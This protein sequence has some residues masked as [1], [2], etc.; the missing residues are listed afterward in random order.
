MLKPNWAAAGLA[1]IVLQWTA[2]ATA[3]NP[4]PAVIVAWN[5]RAQATFPAT[6]G[7]TVSRQYAMLHIAM[8]DAV[9]S[10]EH[11]YTPFRARVP[12]SSGASAKAAAAQAAHDVLANLFPANA[13]AYRTFLEQ[14]LAG[15]PVG[16][17]NPGVKVG[18]AVAAEI[19][20]WRATD[21]AFAP[22]VP[23][24]LPRIPGLWQPTGAPAGMTQVP[25]ITPFTLESATH[26]LVPR[27]PELNT[28]RYATDFEEVRLYGSMN[29]AVR[30]T[31]QTQIAKQWAAFEISDTNLWMIWN[32]VARQVV[33]AHHFSMLQAA[34][35]YALMNVSMIDSLITT[36]TGKFIY[37]LWRPVTAIAGAADDENSATSPEPGW[38]PLLATPPYPSYPGN[39]AGQGAAASKALQL[40]IGSDEF[41]FT[42]TWHGINGNPNT[43][44][45]YTSFS[46]LAQEQ[47][48]SRIWGGIHYRFDNEV[49][50]D[51]CAKLVAHAD[52]NYMTPLQ[53]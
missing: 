21:G 20:A 52:A 9:N 2:P 30:S 27:F 35:L 6:F 41:A 18:K 49:S 48:N 50:Q 42:A 16:L 46:Q 15:I 25:K 51:V 1:A 4:N 17:R 40:A 14:D 43:T 36:Q 38:A 7:P 53:E 37:A 34:R 8:F 47:A 19:L 32:N 5:Q 10:I 13:A 45:N 31:E 44:R 12:A 39:M 29:S 24:V 23:Y 11:G 26:F 22:Q 3:G 28:T 33:Q